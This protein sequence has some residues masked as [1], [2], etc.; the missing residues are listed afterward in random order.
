MSSVIPVLAGFSVIIC[1][2][3]TPFAGTRHCPS[4]CDLAVISSAAASA[5][6]LTPASARLCMGKEQGINLF[7][8]Y[9][10]QQ[11]QNTP[12]SNPIF[13]AGSDPCAE[14]VNSCGNTCATLWVGSR[15]PGNE[16]VVASSGN[17]LRHKARENW[18]FSC[19][20][21]LQK[22]PLQAEHRGC[23]SNPSKP[24]QGLDM[25]NAKLKTFLWYWLAYFLSAAALNT[26]CCQCIHRTI[27]LTPL[28]PF[29]MCSGTRFKMAVSALH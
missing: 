16:G 6:V 29:S 26:T 25:L 21:K 28:P 18:T 9:Y 13:L 7:L 17:F 3:D 11:Q 5:F 19:D 2:L 14:S 27:F 1:L 20:H 23:C 24:R 10:E 15:C 4:G 8:N 12:T 22:T